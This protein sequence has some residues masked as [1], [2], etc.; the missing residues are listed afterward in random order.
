M[1]AIIYPLQFHQKVERRWAS[2]AAAAA[3]VDEMHRSCTR[4]TDTCQC[5]NVVTAPYTSAWSPPNVI[6]TWR[7]SKCG[8]RWKTVAAR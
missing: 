8:A 1:N 5:G 2:Q 6:N 4:G 3:S 7:C